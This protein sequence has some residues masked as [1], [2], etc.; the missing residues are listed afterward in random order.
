MAI[1][2]AGGSLPEPPALA[3]VATPAPLE[4]AEPT[5][6]PV[7]DVVPVMPPALPET[8]G[9]APVAPGPPLVPLEDMPPEDMPLEDV[10]LEE[11]APEAPSFTVPG[12]LSEADGEPPEVAA[13]EPTTVLAPEPAPA[14]APAP[15][16]NPPLDPVDGLVGLRALS[17]GLFTGLFTGTLLD[18][19]PGGEA[20]EPARTTA[21]PLAARIVGAMSSVGTLA[22]AAIALCPPG[23]MPRPSKSAGVM[24]PRA[25]QDG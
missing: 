24:H 19:D 1:G 4:A 21:A 14:P 6:G 3:P 12:A 7:D 9:P 8:A 23:A 10:P 11:P 22:S 16:P 15:A 13:P 18:E 20:V 5:L 17:T 2:R 25:V